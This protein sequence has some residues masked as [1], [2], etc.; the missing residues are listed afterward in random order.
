MSRIIA[1]L[2]FNGNCREAMEFYRDCLGGKLFFQTVG[3]SPLSKKMPVKMKRR[4]LNSFLQS[5]NI[6]LMASDMVGDPGLIRGNSVSILIDCGT[7]KE[8]KLYYENLSKGG[9]AY[10]PVDETFSGALFGS[11]TDR[12]G[13]HWLFNFNKKLKLKN[14]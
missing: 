14:E 12:F 11:L 1:Y 3:E 5:K 7:E 4:I 13:N 10:Y 8:I 6:L 9:E 2:T